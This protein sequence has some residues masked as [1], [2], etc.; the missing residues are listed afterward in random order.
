MKQGK[1]LVMI[2]LIVG[3]LLLF[4]QAIGQELN[5]KVTI[6]INQLQTNQATERQIF[7]EMETLIAGFLNNRE[8]TTDKFEPEERIECRLQ[9]TL[10]QMPSPTNF[11]A[12]AQFQVLRPVYNTNYET[13]LLSYVDREF[14]FQYIQSQPL[15]YNPN[16]FTGNLAALLA[17]YANLALAMDYDSFAKRGGDRYVEQ[18][19][20]IVNFS[21]SAAEP[22]WRRAGDSRNRYWLTEN[23]NNQQFYPL[24]EAIYEYHRHGLDIFLINPE[25]ARENILKALRK[26]DEV[27]KIRPAT[28]LI[29]VFFDTKGLELVNIFSQ[30]TDKQK[31]EAHT[32]LTRLD[33][34]KADMYNRL[35]GKQ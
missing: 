9:I 29:N 19:F 28:V 31:M 30:A 11:T 15:E 32:L 8:W 1:W 23:L 18:M 12:I 2:Y 24:R 16:V 35:I 21:Q 22:G 13:L 14:Q 6:D 10:T 20:N 26:I 7:K 27:N 17:F 34:G 3:W 33:P 4:S 5:C 25:K